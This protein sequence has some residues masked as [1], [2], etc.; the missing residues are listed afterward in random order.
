M[1]ACMNVGVFR[2]ERGRLEGER[3]N[4]FLHTCICDNEDFNN[5]C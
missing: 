2:Q 4:K 1:P 3:E 5:E